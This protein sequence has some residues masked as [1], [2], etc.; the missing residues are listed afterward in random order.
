MAARK[1][2]S[3][4]RKG[5]KSKRLRIRWIITPLFLFF[6]ALVSA[7]IYL[8]GAGRLP[9][10]LGLPIPAS[11]DD[12]EVLIHH[13]FF[14][15]GISSAD[16]ISE[17]KRFISGK[18]LIEIQIS[19]PGDASENRLVQKLRT[20][21][22]TCGLKIYDDLKKNAA[23]KAAACIVAGTSERPTHIIKLVSSHASAKRSDSSGKKH[24]PYSNMSS[25][26]SKKKADTSKLSTSSHSQPRIAL[27]I[28]DVGSALKTARD[29]LSLDIPITLAV[30]P[31]LKFSRSAAISAHEAGQGIM[32]HLPMEPRDY[33]R[34]DPGPGKLLVAMSPPELKRAFNTDFESVPYVQGVNNHMGSRFTSDP[35]ALK[36]VLEEIRKR[37]L[38][39]VDSRTSGDS[40]A[41]DEAKKMGI[42]TIKRDVFLDNDSAFNSIADMMHAL[43][44]KAKA[45]GAAVGIAHA[46]SSS[47]SALKRL[48]PQSEKNGFRFVHISQLVD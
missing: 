14:N 37:N 39:F 6:L 4:A 13:C 48:V 18:L 42:K 24:R 16:V 3:S 32:L 36:P 23:G 38:F 34:I 22:K 12:A 15:N 10:Y 35:E 21:F 11:P 29:F 41:F 19:I 31:H 46:R 33:P 28:D 2:K 43:Q 45:A 30:L 20:A 44:N 7:F 1:S 17:K 25:P 26:R 8:I 9:N 27:I 47:F 5:K 40:V